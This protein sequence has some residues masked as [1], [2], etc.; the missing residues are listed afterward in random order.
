MSQKLVWGMVL[1]VLIISLFSYFW[2]IDFSN[3][4]KPYT[5]ENLPNS[6][7]VK[8]YFAFYPRLGQEHELSG[9]NTKKD[10]INLLE[11]INVRRSIVPAR[12][13]NIYPTPLS[14]YGISLQ[15]PNEFPLEI[16]ILDN[17]Y[18]S[19]NGQ[20][21]RIVNSPDLARIFELVVLDRPEDRALQDIYELIK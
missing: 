15:N 7:S 17:Q 20:K 4:I 9:F 13:K 1:I 12:L 5:Q 3:L 10:V 14:T 8:V 19:V 2:V 21:Y 18:I 11:N 6:L 16:K